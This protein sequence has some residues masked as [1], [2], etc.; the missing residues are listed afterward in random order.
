M[1]ANRTQFWAWPP[2][3]A[4]EGCSPLMRVTCATFGRLLRGFDVRPQV[5]AEQSWR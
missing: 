2:R 1:V 4:E 5:A 3:F